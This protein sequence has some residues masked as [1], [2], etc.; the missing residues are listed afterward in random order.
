MDILVWV[1]PQKEWWVNQD[2]NQNRKKQQSDW[3]PDPYLIYG[4]FIVVQH[5]EKYIRLEGEESL[6]SGV[7]MVKEIVID[8]FGK[9]D[10]TATIIGT[11]EDGVQWDIWMNTRMDGF[12]KVFA[13]I[14]TTRKP[15]FII[16]END[17]T[18]LVKY[19]ICDGYF[20]FLPNIPEKLQQVQEVRLDPQKN[21]LVG[22]KGSNLFVNTFEIVDVDR[23]SKN[24]RQVELY[25]FIS[26]E[27][28]NGL[29]ELEIHSES[30]FL[31]KGDSMKMNIHWEIIEVE[32]DS[33]VINQLNQ[34]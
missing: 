16:S 20:T 22:K 34:L 26:K 9:V 30:K 1:G 13:P 14:D 6:V 32:N 12:D 24:H 23:I 19:K 29:L 15:N 11:R 8:E 7:K 31:L 33:A 2:I 4:D 28:E 17:Q 25:N 18:E 5:D 21:F 3:P 10:F 27:N